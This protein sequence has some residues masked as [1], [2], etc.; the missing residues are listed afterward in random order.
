MRPTPL[1]RAWSVASRLLL[2]VA[3]RVERRKVLD[4]GMDPARAGEK[5]GHATEARP[6]GPLI[7]FHAASVGESLSVLSL[8]ERMGQALPRA[9][10][11]ITSGTPTSADLV[12][13]RMPPRCRHQFAP[14]D[15]PGPLRRFLSHWRPDAAIFVESE[16]W[17]QMVVRTHQAGVPLAL[18]NARMSERSAA[19]WRRLPRT[20][21]MLLGSFRL[22]LTQTDDLARILVTLGAESGRVR[23]GPNLKALSA[24]LPMDES[25]VAMMRERLENRPVWVAASTHPGEEELVL[26]A[27][28]RLLET[29]PDL[30]LIL[31]PRHPARGD[32]VA[33]MISERGWPV[34]RRSAGDRPDGSVYLADTLGELGSWY[35]LAPFAFLG[36]SLTPVGGHNPYE[37]AQA[38]AAVL[39]GPHVFNFEDT[40]AAMTRAGCARIVDD[41]QAL[42]QAADLWLSNEKACDAA[43][44]AARA[45]CDAGIDLL[46]SVA[47]DLAEALDLRRA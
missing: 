34:P 17:P 6:N 4:A 39:T 23:K 41:P 21:H 11:L 30:C 38:G 22:I 8:I 10:F 42:A 27:H 28:A 2:P 47:A 45:F 25:L 31:A 14:L 46:D 18:V 3:A 43:R 33:A 16:L 26:N 44:A 36:G 20:A 7:W 29:H 40:F 35:A 13:R 5:L 9:Q 1:Y 15:A 32:E 37:V 12:A 24:P 19:R